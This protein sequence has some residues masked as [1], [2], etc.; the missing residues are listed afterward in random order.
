MLLD[1]RWKTD[2]LSFPIFGLLPRTNLFWLLLQT[3]LPP[4]LEATLMVNLTTSTASSSTTSTSGQDCALLIDF[5][6]SWFKDLSVPWAPQ[7]TSA[8]DVSWALSFHSRIP[9]L[10]T[11][12]L[13]LSSISDFKLAA[14]YECGYTDATVGSRE[15][16]NK[17][18]LSPN[19]LTTCWLAFR[20][21]FL[22]L[23]SK[24]LC[25][26][27]S[28]KRAVLRSTSVPC[29]FLRF[30]GQMTERP[31]RLQIP[32]TQTSWRAMR[33]KYWKQAWHLPTVTQHVHWWSST[34][35][36]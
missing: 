12:F 19:T 17:S 9:R 14:E 1:V 21:F 24:L 23:S 3:W 32:N 16:M 7:W 18:V 4:S 33:L 11:P 31:E 20:S 28:I 25:W 36:T 22:S 8:V 30:P 5:W 6:R 2:Y 13:P 26:Q 34:T 29:S 15:F 27:T 10:L 35:S